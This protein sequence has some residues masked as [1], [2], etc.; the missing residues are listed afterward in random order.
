MALSLL[1]KKQSDLKLLQTCTL[2]IV[3]SLGRVVQRYGPVVGTSHASL[4]LIVRD[5][6]RTRVRF[7]STKYAGK[8]CKLSNAAKSLE[9]ARLVRFTKGFTMALNLSIQDLM[10]VSKMLSHLRWPSKSCVLKTSV[11]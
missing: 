2:K 6:S 4:M 7:R 9:K 8:S 10:V 5:L 3:M 1:T 11:F